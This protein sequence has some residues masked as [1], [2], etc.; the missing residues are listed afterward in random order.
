MQFYSKK[1]IDKKKKQLVDEKQ[2][3][4]LTHVSLSLKSFD[5]QVSEWRSQ[6]V[7]GHLQSLYK[8]KKYVFYILT[9]IDQKDVMSLKF[10]TS[11]QWCKD[12][13]H[14]F[15]VIAKTWD[16]LYNENAVSNHLDWKI[17]PIDRLTQ[18]GREYIDAKEKEKDDKTIFV[19]EE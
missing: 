7:L 10:K 2:K 4:L 13:N 19:L 12:N 8:K 18:L 1:L 3:T 11:V 17:I 16:P 14:L 5:L 15:V 6:T 9:D